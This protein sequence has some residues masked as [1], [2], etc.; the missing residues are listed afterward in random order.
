M[1]YRQTLQLPKTTFPMRAGLAQKEPQRLAAWEEGKAYE[2][3]QKKGSEQARPTFVLHD[4]PPYANGHIHLG[5]TLNKVLKDFVVR[6]RAMDGYLTPYVPGWDTHG[7]P[8][9]LQVVKEAGVDRHN[10]SPLEFRRRCREYALRFVDI[11]RQEFKRLGVWGDWENPYLTLAPKYE[12]EQ[13]RVFG[14]MAE[15]GYIYKGLKPVYWCASCETA[16]AEAEVEYGDHRS[17]SVYVAFEVTDDRGL[18]DASQHEAAVVIWTT[19]PWTLPANL[20]I[21]VHPDV[22]YALVQVAGR[23]YVV[24]EA[25]V[26]A[27]AAQVGWEEPRIVRTIKGQELEGV[28]CRHPFIDRNSLVILGDHVTLEQGTGCVHT[29][30]GHGIEDYEVGVRYDLDVLAPVDGR[31][32][33][34]SDAGPYAGQSVFEANAVIVADL[35][36][37]GA[38]LAHRHVEHSYPHCWR[39]R[40]PVIFRAT[41]QWFASV[42]GFRDEAL[43]AIRN[44]EWIPGWGQDRI[45]GMVA[46]RSDWCIS[47]QRAWGVP[48]PIFYCSDCREPLVT[49][50]SIEAV[51]QAFEK[52]GSD[53]WYSRAAADILPAGTV[54]TG[55]GGNRFDKE[56]DIMDVWF[57]SGSSHSAVLEQH[58]SLRR[59]A[60]LYLEG[61]DQ[62]RGWFQSSLLTAVATVGEPPFRAVLTHGYIVDG[63]GRKMSKSLGNVIAPQDLI[64]QYGADILRLWVASS[65]YRGDVRFSETILEQVADVYRRIRNTSRF[66]LGNLSDFDPARD[67]VADT[68]LDELDSW[69]LTRARR[70][71]GRVVKAYRDYEFHLVYHSVHNFCS[72]DLG[73]F[74]LDVV[75]DRVYCEAAD[76]K[77][78]RSAQTA[79]HEL[80]LLLTQ[81]IAPIL[82]FTAEEVWEHVPQAS[83]V[84]ESVHLLRWPQPE[85]LAVD[86]KIEARWER[87]LLLRK[88]AARALEDARN[89]K[90]IASSQ[91]AD[92]ALYTSSDQ[93]YN[94]LQPF[95]PRL[96][97][98]LIAARVTLLPPGTTAPAAGVKQTDHGLTVVVQRTV[99][100][101]CP[102]CWRH[103][104]EAAEG[105]DALCKRCAGVL[106]GK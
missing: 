102:R 101:K 33:F 75:K 43:A 37:D 28:V 88:V 77:A 25:L 12:A 95:A 79:M 59:P 20:A 27:V 65:D 105:E 74:Y 16:L 83:R 51:A 104:V 39:C 85:E 22:D 68:D 71:F 98:L 73:G 92:V 17:D 47:R 58:P 91:E 90:V 15:R 48:I 62:H 36:A 70:L 54:C 38:L 55:C 30:P 97:E 87:M 84:E 49:S 45:T 2:T 50:E 31:G 96:G 94:A 103:V 56:S 82:P 66:L 3:L 80:L 41:E 100:A 26:P 6:S 40:N 7:L 67:G 21:A 24:A 44:V 8:I 53:A 72:V 1:D 18:L 35:R 32:R 23:R 93:A 42:D 29:A 34:T 13:V 46:D 99:D 9:E 86:P 81:A 60:D 52:E 57:D 106:E 64:D 19:T 4:G 63:E 89:Q 14:A 5:T 69:V 76:S 78:R 11:Q 61:S 10:L